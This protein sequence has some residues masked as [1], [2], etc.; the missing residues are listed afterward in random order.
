MNDATLADILR[1]LKALEQTTVRYRAG[2][3]T[4]TGPLDVALGGASTSYEDVSAVGDA[5]TGEHVATLLW[6]NDLLVLGPVGSG[7]VPSARVYNDAN[8]SIDHNTLTALTF[9]TERYDTAS[10]HSTSSNTSRLTAPTAGL[11]IIGGSAQFAVNATGRRRVSIRL[12][13]TTEIAVQEPAVDA[14]AAI[15][16]SAALSTSYELAASDYVELLVF[17]TSGGAL[18]VAAQNNHSPEFWIS[19]VR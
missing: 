15:N 11:Y 8:I 13:G 6:G 9:N 2:E 4:D 18:N 7:S 14:D 10:F 5:R 3:V 16:W 19:R 17:Q 1:R 12:N